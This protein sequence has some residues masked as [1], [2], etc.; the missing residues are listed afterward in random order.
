MIGLFKVSEE[1]IYDTKEIYKFL[2]QQYNSQF[3][4]GSKTSKII[5]HEINDRS[6]DLA[7]I[8]FND[9]DITNGINKLKN[10]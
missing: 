8:K 2:T 3:S 4:K 6:C 10:N 5:D 9:N 7:D 1:Y